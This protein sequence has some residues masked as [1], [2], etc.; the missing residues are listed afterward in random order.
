MPSGKT[1]WCELVVVHEGKDKTLHLHAWC[2]GDATDAVQQLSQLGYKMT[3]YK[4]HVLHVNEGHGIGVLGRP[5]DGVLGLEEWV[6]LRD[7]LAKTGFYN[8][9][10]RDINR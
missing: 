3:D 6:K 10:D 1:R 9:G 7:S 8:A 2:P 4:S 5:K